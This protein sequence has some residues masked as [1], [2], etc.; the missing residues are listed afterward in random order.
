MKPDPDGRDH[1][2]IVRSNEVQSVARAGT[3]TV[4]GKTVPQKFV[5][6]GWPSDR[7]PRVRVLTVDSAWG[8]DG[9]AMR[10]GAKREVWLHNERTNTWAYWDASGGFKTAANPY[11]HEIDGIFRPRSE[12]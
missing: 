4:A 7:T 10:G 9:D 2:V 3:I 5:S 12:P 11:H 8:G 1:K 6:D